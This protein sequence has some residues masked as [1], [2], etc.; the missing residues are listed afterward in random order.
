MQKQKEKALEYTRKW[1]VTANVS[2]CAVLVVVVVVVVVFITYSWLV[3]R[4]TPLAVS[5]ARNERR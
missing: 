2:K 5:W 3:L 1:R 4:P